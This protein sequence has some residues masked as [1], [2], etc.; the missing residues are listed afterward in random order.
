[1][2]FAKITVNSLHIHKQVSPHTT[3]SI[4]PTQS[5]AHLTPTL[6]TPSAPILKTIPFPAS[7]SNSSTDPTPPQS[8][9]STPLSLLPPKSPPLSRTPTTYTS[10]TC[11][12]KT[13]KTNIFINGTSASNMNY[14]VPQLFN[15][16]LL[17]LI[18]LT[19]THIAFISNGHDIISFE[20]SSIY[21]NDSSVFHPFNTNP[22]D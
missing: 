21:G 7:S 3:L 12:I 14:I 1:M 20:L 19:I 6:T 17:I 13:T 9:H 11:N 22:P 16:F 4:S 2:K 8:N 18:Y 15:I 5:T 10:T